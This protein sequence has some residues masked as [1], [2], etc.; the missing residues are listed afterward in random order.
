M[1]RMY[2]PL[3]GQARSYTDRRRTMRSGGRRWSFPCGI[4]PVYRN[5]AYFSGT[6]FS[7]E[8]VGSHTAEQLMCPISE[9]R[10][11]PAKA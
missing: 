8:C 9:C 2:R 11:A 6:G 3:R 10:S 1:R 4:E 7:R 5:I